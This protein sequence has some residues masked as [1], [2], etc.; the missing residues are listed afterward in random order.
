MAEARFDLG[1][2][3]GWNAAQVLGSGFDQLQFGPR[4]RQ[5]RDGVLEVGVGHLVGVQLGAVAGQVED[6]DVV[7]VL[8]QPS[9]QRPDSTTLEK[10]VSVPPT[11]LFMPS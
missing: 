10:F 6:F 11:H 9:L 3:E 4:R 5:S 7:P 2:L 8:G 1:L